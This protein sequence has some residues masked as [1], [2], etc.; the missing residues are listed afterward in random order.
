[1]SPTSVYAELSGNRNLQPWWSKVMPVTLQCPNCQKPLAIP[2]K[3][4]GSTVACPACATDFLAA[5]PPQ[6]LPSTAANHGV[7]RP[8]PPGRGPSPVWAAIV[9]PVKVPIAVVPSP[10][11]IPLARVQPTTPPPTLP[12]SVVPPPLPVEAT[13]LPD[14][15]CSRDGQQVG[16]I[17]SAQLKA[18]AANGQLRP[19]DLVW[20]EGMANWV[21]A[22]KTKGLFPDFPPSPPPIPQMRAPAAVLASPPP[23]PGGKP[24]WQ[25]TSVPDPAR[26]PV[27]AITVAG[28]GKSKAHLIIGGSVFFFVASFLVFYGVARQFG[29]GDAQIE[30]TVASASAMK[31][32]GGTILYDYYNNEVAAD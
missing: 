14:W 22:S 8:A 23:L 18:L 5:W 6:P 30:Q 26:Q 11:T 4:V 10:P 21:E 16:P 28:R 13:V 27:R 15:F 19:S 12:P 7:I 29:D 9:P 3:K 2:N 17:S 25:P 24:L 1:M 20:N 32:D 31:V